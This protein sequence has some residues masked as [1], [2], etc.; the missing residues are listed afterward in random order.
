M[1]DIISK[2]RQFYNNNKLKIWRDGLAIILIILFVHIFNNQV[3]S[4]SQSHEIKAVANNT[5]YIE[6]TVKRETV[7]SKTK[8]EQKDKIEQFIQLC[9]NGNVSGAYGMLSDDCKDKL[10]NSEQLF[11]QSYFSKIFSMKRNYSEIDYSLKTSDNITIYKVKLV[12]D[13]MA[14]AGED[15]NAYITDYFSI[16][17]D[18]KLQVANFLLSKKL[19]KMFKNE[20]MIVKIEEETKFVNRVT[21]KIEIKNL[22]KGNIIVTNNTENKNII[23]SDEKNKEYFSEQEINEIIRPNESK[24]LTIT[25]KK[26]YSTLAN[27]NEISIKNILIESGLINNETDNVTIKVRDE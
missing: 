1:Q 11:H 13:I 25:F 7:T 3:K 12:G 16:T 26:E 15:E 23:M 8:E 27:T 4:D 14:S 24:E 20:S 22:T 9:N 18:G 6:P 17:D 10:Y 2:F 5:V 19:N 21:Y